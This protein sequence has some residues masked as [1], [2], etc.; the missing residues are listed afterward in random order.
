MSQPIL[1]L[2]NSLN[3]DLVV[4]Q[5]YQ[6]KWLSETTFE[7]LPDQSFTLDSRLLMVGVKCSKAQNTWWL[8]A[9]L[10][11]RLPVLPSSTSQFPASV[12]A[13]RKRC[14]LDSLT[15]IDFPVLGV[16]PYILNV[17]FPYWFE[18]ASLEIW[19]YSGPDTTTD[20]EA[21]S[22]IEEKLNNRQ[23]NVEF[24]PEG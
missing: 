19:K 10:S 14:R 18:D 13:C 23:L 1:D 22:R 17:E 20:S 16:S 11:M 7:A 9:R 2:S 5:T 8:G 4:R 6:V 21:L 3:W 15:L 12:E 24:I